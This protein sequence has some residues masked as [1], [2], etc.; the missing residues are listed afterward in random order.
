[1][2]VTALAVLLALQA[3]SSDRSPRCREEQLLAMRRAEEQL[4]RGDEAAAR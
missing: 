3:A 2:T 4:A 1:V